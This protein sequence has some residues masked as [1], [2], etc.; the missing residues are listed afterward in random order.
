MKYDYIIIGGGPTALTLA[1]YF[2]E[3]K[4]KCL[5]LERDNN[6]GGC[7]SVRLVNNYFSEHGP[8][9]YSSAFINF[10]SLLKKMD[11]NFYDYFVLYKD[12]EI[13]ETS[14]YEKIYLIIGYI[15]YLLYP[16]YFNKISVK[17]YF[18]NLSNEFNFK[19]NRLCILTDGMDYSKYSMTKFFNLITQ[20]MFCTLY[21]PKYPNNI[22]LFK[23]WLNKLDK[24]YITIL[25][26]SEVL[27]INYNHN[28]IINVE[29]INNMYSAEKYILCIPP[30]PMYNL[31]LNSNIPNVF[32]N[33]FK[34]WVNKNS[35]NDYISITFHFNNKM[36]IN[37]KLDY[38]QSKNG[39]IYIVVSNYFINCN[40][41]II[42]T[43]LSLLTDDIHILSKN[44]LINETFKQLLQYLPELPQY[45]KAIMNPN[46]VKINNKWV[47]LDTNFVSTID[48]N[49]LKQESKIIK[50]IFNVGTQNNYNKYD[51]TT[52]ETAI[53]NALFFIKKYH[54]KKIN[55]KQT[56]DI[57][58]YIYFLILIVILF[59]FL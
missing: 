45:D 56:I 3:L 11:I 40:T 34:Q 44:E 8:R 35:Y 13:L 33:N 9:V 43:S 20:N 53:I 58:K 32:K 52:I 47:S 46:N 5:I 25:T 24:K 4:I 48:Y 17:S 41:T 23:L 57:K 19:I 28:K 2:S 27:K 59:K 6:I 37:K 1:Y 36:I 16:I 51:F 18:N 14:L 42:S 49:F 21:Q 29:T 30:K 39:L 54:N 7:H 38:P 12:I 50:N 55:I 26:N 31:L 22:G 15:C 10:I